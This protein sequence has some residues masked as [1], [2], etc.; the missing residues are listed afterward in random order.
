MKGDDCIFTDRTY[1]RAQLQGRLPG[2]SVETFSTLEQLYGL[3]PL[4]T[5][6]IMYYGP[7]LIEALV[8]R[9][10]DER[11]SPSARRLSQGNARR[12][13]RLSKEECRQQKRLLRED[14]RSLA[15]TGKQAQDSQ[16]KSENVKGNNDDG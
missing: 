11:V 14:V 4:T 8:R 10:K 13:Q 16:Q 7:H 3:L 5:D 9:A 1:T 2:A 15:P 6:P 12:E